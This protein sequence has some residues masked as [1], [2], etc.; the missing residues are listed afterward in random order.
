[1]TRVQLVECAL[2][3]F[4]LLPSLAEFTFRRQALVVGKVSGCFRN[5]R[6]EIRCG[7]G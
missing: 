3:L 4:Q 5:K 6:I 1:L 2:Q 7:L